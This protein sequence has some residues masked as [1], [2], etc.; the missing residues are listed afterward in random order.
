M[1]SYPLGQPLVLHFS[2]LDNT[3]GSPT[4]GQPQA[5]TTVALVIRGPNDG[6]STTYTLA[7]SQITLN[8]DGSYSRQ[9]IPMESGPWTYRWI[10]TG[11][12]ACAT[13]DLTL[14]IANSSL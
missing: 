12:W 11:A 4:F 8:A 3:V 5:P 13:L 14:P 6:A 2:V 1:A 7:L 9:I 10:A